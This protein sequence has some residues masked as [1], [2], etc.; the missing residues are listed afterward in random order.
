MRVLVKVAVFPLV[1]VLT[2]AGL[3]VRVFIK[4]GSMVAGVAT[5]LLAI[6]AILALVNKMWLQLGIFGIIFAAMMFCLLASAELQVWI[7]VATERL[8]SV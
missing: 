1:I 4:L 8:K 2:L 3:L 6:C 5:L 7:D